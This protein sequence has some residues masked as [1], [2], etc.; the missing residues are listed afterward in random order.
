M[1]A[2]FT[3]AS[4][5]LNSVAGESVDFALATAG[6]SP[7]VIVASS[8]TMSDYHDK[9]MRPH[10]GM[11]SS[12]ARWFQVRNLDAGVMPSQNIFSQLAKIGPTAE[13]SLDRLRLLCISHRFDADKDVRLT[14]EQLTDFR[15]FTGARIAYALTGPGIAGAI[16]QTNIFDYRRVN[17]PSH[18]GAPLSSAEVIL[19]EFPEDAGLEKAVVGKVRAQSSS[20]P[21]FF[22]S[23]FSDHRCRPFCCR[24]QQNSACSSTLPR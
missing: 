20:Y 12:I 23:P 21:F 10:T 8:H 7:T 16:T 5:A 2:L 1:A 4:V 11:I 24:R 15:I 17:G 13:L 22:C 3:N 14:S 19:T 6:V 18:F 9:F